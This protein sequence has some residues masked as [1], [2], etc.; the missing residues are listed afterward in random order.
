[1]PACDKEVVLPQD[2]RHA[3]K[4][5]QRQ[6]RSVDVDDGVSGRVGVGDNHR[7][8]AGFDCLD[9]CATLLL[10]AGDVATGRHFIVM[11]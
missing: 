10:Q 2:L 9:E 5:Q 1:M 3:L 6:K 11:L 7:H 8:P 4:A